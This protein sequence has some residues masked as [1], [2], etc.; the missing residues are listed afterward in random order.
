M[1]DNKFRRGYQL[2]DF[3]EPWKTYLNFDPPQPK[4]PASR[5]SEIANKDAPCDTISSADE[6]RCNLSPITCNLVSRDTISPA[7]TSPGP[8]QKSAAAGA[9]LLSLAAWPRGAL[10]CADERSKPLKRRSVSR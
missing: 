5:G 6:V 2:K 1:E 10:F 7:H 4:V 8:A 3:Q 9:N